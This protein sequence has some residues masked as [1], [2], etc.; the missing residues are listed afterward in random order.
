MT[1][2]HPI[3]YLLEGLLSFVNNPLKFKHK[4][5]MI[6]ISD[7]FPLLKQGYAKY[8]T[9]LA[10]IYI[11][12]IKNRL[13]PL[14]TTEVFIPDDVMIKSF[15]SNIPSYFYNGGDKVAFKIPMKIAVKHKLIDSPKNTFEMINKYFNVQNFSRIPMKFIK[16]L[17]LFN[18]NLL[19]YFPSQTLSFNLDDPEFI[20]QI[21]NEDSLMWNLYLLINDNK[22]IPDILITSMSN[23]KYYQLSK[24]L[25]SDSRIDPSINNQELF[26]TAIKRESE[27]IVALFLQRVQIDPR[28]N[29]N[30]AY[31]EAV[32]TGNKNIIDIIYEASIQR[33]IYEES[34]FEQAQL[35]SDIYRYTRSFFQ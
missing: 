25:L 21:D 33:N 7:Y 12:I 16:A 30:Q 29:N 27:Q 19:A 20:T 13:Y 4:S 32:E 22:Q 6:D 35:P 28:I 9:V 15:G 3:L 10:Y 14:A 17:I 23:S 34:V 31:Y 1:E 11:Y 5:E 26:L 18:A 2:T 8:G 24:K